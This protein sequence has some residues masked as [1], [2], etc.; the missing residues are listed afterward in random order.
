MRTK[1]LV[2]VD[3]RR[4]GQVVESPEDVRV[5]RAERLVGGVAELRRLVLGRRQLV[6]PGRRTNKLTAAA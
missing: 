5:A 3:P 1:N 2:L 4:L 6:R